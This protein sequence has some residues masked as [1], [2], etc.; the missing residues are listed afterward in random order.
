MIN[1]VHLSHLPWIKIRWSQISAIYNDYKF[2]FFLRNFKRPCYRKWRLK[3]VNSS[4]IRQNLYLRLLMFR[5]AHINWSGCFLRRFLSSSKTNRNYSAILAISW[6][7]VS[8]VFTV[9]GKKCNPN[10]NPNRKLTEMSLTGNLFT[11]LELRKL[12]L[13]TFW[14]YFDILL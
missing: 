6:P 12:H 7:C 8:G 13:S 5:Y 4:S 10:P 14:I 9:V 3:D 1:R 2:K 11:D